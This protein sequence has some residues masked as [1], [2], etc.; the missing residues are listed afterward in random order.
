MKEFDIIKY[1]ESPHLLK[2]VD[3]DSIRNVIKEFPY[4]Q[5]AHMLLLKALHENDSTSFQEQ[6][7]KSSIFIS[8]RNK[9]Y[10]FLNTKSD[11]I[12]PEQIEEKEE[13]LQ[14]NPSKKETKS[15]PK[16]KL[17]KNKNVR[18]KINNS[19]EGMGQNISDTITSQLEFS[20][21]KEDD[22]LEYP[23]EIYFIEDERTGK[24]NVITIDAEPDDAKLTQK[25]KDILQID[26]TPKKEKPETEI[27]E[28]EDSFEL[29]NSESKEKKKPEKQTPYFDIDN[30]AGES[31][32][33]TSDDLISRFIKDQ[34]Q[35]KPANTKSENADISE[36]SV[37]EDND[38]LSETL[39]KVYI[40]QGLFEKAIKAYSKLCLKYPEKNAYFAS[41]IELLK[42]KINN[43]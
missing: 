6:L 35:I 5:S 42:E 21:I 20:I 9:L 37:K 28:I 29:I 14:E 16:N 26:E 19:F 7:A 3:V 27:K 41:Q 38:L 18:R 11:N 43:K 33:K 24:N 15:K 23:S 25:P 12:E 17:L 32:L 36:E 40:K 10:E 1:I 39:I 2:Q 31:T 4:Y 22:K 30:Y 34:P 8:D 13:V